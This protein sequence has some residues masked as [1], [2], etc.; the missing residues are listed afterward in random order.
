MIRRLILIIITIVFVI[1]VGVVE[2]IGQ[3]R[4]LRLWFRFVVNGVVLDIV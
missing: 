1:F 2:H 4:M 3:R